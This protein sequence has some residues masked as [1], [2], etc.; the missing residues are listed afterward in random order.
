[1]GR[2][3]ST[4]RVIGLVTTAM[5]ICAC[6]DS[7]SMSSPEVKARGASETLPGAGSDKA[8]R[9]LTRGMVAGGA[10]GQMQDIE[11]AAIALIAGVTE[12]LDSKLPDAAAALK[13]ASAYTQEAKPD[14]ERIGAQIL[15]LE[16][17]KEARKERIQIVA[18]RFVATL[19]AYERTVARFELVASDE[20]LVHFNALMKNFT[21]PMRAH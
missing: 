14:A 13:A 6:Q 21:S 17:D 11:Q 1:M 15:A 10:R 5:L 9:G 7:H 18:R 12:A 20:Q 8:L 2:M 4:A 3:M 19:D 16:L